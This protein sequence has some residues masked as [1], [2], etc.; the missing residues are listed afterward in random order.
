MSINVI[1]VDVDIYKVYF[2]QVDNSWNFVSGKVVQHDTLL[3]QVSCAMVFS[4]PGSDVIVSCGVVSYSSRCPVLWYFL[5]QEVMWL[6]LVMFL[7]RSLVQDA[8]LSTFFHPGSCTLQYFHI[9]YDCGYVTLFFNSICLIFRSLPV[10]T[11]YAASVYQHPISFCV[12]ACSASE[13]RIVPESCKP[14]WQQQQ[15]QQQWWYIW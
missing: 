7:S 12:F 8:S 3:L 2:I 14:G 1:K 6:C 5:G 13:V 10:W 15:Q 9:A 4:R 11:C